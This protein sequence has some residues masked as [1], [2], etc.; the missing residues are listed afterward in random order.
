MSMH[1][2]KQLED[3]SILDLTT[4][5]ILG[6]G[7]NRGSFIFVPS[8]PKLKEKWFMFFQ[9]ACEKLALDKT[10]SGAS[11]RVLMY[12]L[13][14]LDF[15]NYILIQQVEIAEKLE[16]K[17][18]NVSRA[19]KQLTDKGILVKGPKLGRTYSYKLNSTYGWKGKVIKLFEEMEEP[20][21][22]LLV[23]TTKKS[24]IYPPTL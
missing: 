2:F 24:G 20:K 23:D 17:R 6:R 14:N 16:M 3:G 12:L 7:E 21:P 8:K 13:S 18:A 4:G 5:E 10:L 19:I 15:E 9:N 1:Q 22:K 11:F